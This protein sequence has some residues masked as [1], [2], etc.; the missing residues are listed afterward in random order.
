MI[1]TRV[2]RSLASRLPQPVIERLN[3]AQV[4][5]PRLASSLQSIGGRIARGEGPCD[6]APP[7]AFAL[8]LLVECPAMS[9][10]RLIMR[11]S[12]ARRATQT[13]RH[14]LRHRGEHRLFHTPCRQTVS[15]RRGRGI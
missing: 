13:R 11:N 8:M 10:V 14:L 12:W 3:D 7:L 15:A 1:L 5:H 4:G 9:W 6:A 2:L